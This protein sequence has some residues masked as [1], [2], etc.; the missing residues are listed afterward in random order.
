MESSAEKVML[1]ILFTILS[2]RKME[3]NSK[4]VRI[5]HLSFNLSCVLL[6]HA[7]K[8]KPKII[9]V[10]SPKRLVYSLCVLNPVFNNQVHVQMMVMIEQ[11]R[12]IS[13]YLSLLTNKSY[14]YYL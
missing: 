8:N 13:S 4:T 9:I 3:P 14:I 7:K 10:S 1:R 6:I 5:M 11:L 2:D 12:S